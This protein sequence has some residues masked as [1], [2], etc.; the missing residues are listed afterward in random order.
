VRWLIVLVALALLAGCAGPSVTSGQKAPQDELVW[1]PPPQ[2]ARIKYNHDFS[3]P[4]DLGI[5]TP[6]LSRFWGWI[7]GKQSAERMVRPY[8][9]A[10]NQE[11]IAVADPGSKALHLYNKK[12]GTYKNIRRAGD[13][14]L[15]SPVGVAISEDYLFLS[16]SETEKVFVLN[17]NGDYISTI[18][19][20]KRPTGLAY[21]FLNHRLYVSD[22]LNHQVVVYNDKGDRLFTIGERTKQKG[23]FN[24]PSHLFIAN[25]RLYVNDTM[26]FRI[27]IFGLDGKYITAFGKH[28]DASG[29]FSQPK[30]VGV[31]S[32]G[33]I[34]VVDAIFHRV[35][36]FDE[37]GQYLIAFGSQGKGAAEF[38][39]P[40][41]LFIV[42]DRIYV[43]DSYNRRIQVFE[44]VGG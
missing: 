27:Q 26:N 31:D 16:D 28:G 13:S 10:A 5:R 41:G 44:Y 14:V 23:G 19:D 3:S 8:S 6:L 43:A 32:R 25:N 35:Q 2:P 12:K 36:V 20:M 24:F 29:H 22:T 17:H 37:K 34:Y 38:W 42:Q 39:L 40:T 33:H 9:I 4:K 1:P 30:G 7:S 18:T 15:V 11:L 21:D